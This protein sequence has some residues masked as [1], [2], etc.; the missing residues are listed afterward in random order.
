[1]THEPTDVTR[2]TVQLHATV[3][4]RQDVIAGLLGITP[5]TLRAHYRAELDFATAKANA[6]IGGALFNKAKNGDTTAQ[7]FWMK[8]R[9]HWRETSVTEI[10]GKDGGPVQEVRRIVVDPKAIEEKGEDDV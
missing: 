3:G 6:Q 1:M 4:T 10:Q 8:T 5:K 2:Q 9:A 7:I